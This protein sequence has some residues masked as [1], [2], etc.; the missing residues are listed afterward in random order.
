MDVF[1]PFFRPKFNTQ[2]SKIDQKKPLWALIKVHYERSQYLLWA[3]IRFSFFKIQYPEFINWPKKTLMSAHKSPLWAISHNQKYFL[4]AIT[5]YPEFK[6]NCPKKT[7][8]STHKSPLWAIK[9]I[10][11]NEKY[12]LWAVTIFVV[13][14]HKVL[15]FATSFQKQ[16]SP[17]L[18]PFSTQKLIMQYSKKLWKKS[19]VSAHNI[20]PLTTQSLHLFIPTIWGNNVP[21][22]IGFPR[23]DYWK[24]HHNRCSR[25][26]NTQVASWYN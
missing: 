19:Y 23:A 21:V 18:L 6:K 25:S 5:Q 14:A 4:W 26:W 10:S 1:C 13:S 16:F 24:N 8:M 17:N 20:W 9:L 22:C 3:L 7:L 12:L 15:T 2:N 11:P